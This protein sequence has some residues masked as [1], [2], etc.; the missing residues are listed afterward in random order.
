[1]SR[2]TRPVW[3]FINSVKRTPSPDSL[4]A[5][6]LFSGAGLSDAGYAC[7]GFRFIVH[8]ELEK[9]RAAI[10]ASNFHDSKWIVGDARKVG[11]HVVAEYIKA[12]DRRLDLLVA[13]PP[14]QGMSSSNPSRGKRGTKFAGD[15]EAKN[16]LLL[17]LIPVAKRLRPRVIVAENVRQ[18]LTHTISYRNRKVRIIERLRSALSDYEIFEGVVNVADYGVPQD[19]RRAI[20]VA[21]DKNEPWLQALKKGKVSPWPSHTHGAASAESWI[22]IREWFEAIQYTPLDA[23]SAER[24]SNGHALH[25]V[26][27]YDDHRYLWVSSIP[28]YSGKSAYDNSKCPECGAQDIPRGRIRCPRCNGLL[29]NRPFVPCR[30]GGRLI[31]GFDSSYRRMPANLPARTITTNTSHL[32]SDYKIHPWEHRV[33]S[34]LECA[35]LQTVPRW[36]DWSSA[37]NGG[38]AYLIRKVIGESFPAYFTY[39][40]GQLLFRL[41]TSDSEHI[42]LDE[43]S[44]EQTS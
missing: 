13:T 33:L 8:V 18:V 21:I 36:F 22:T 16:R 11:R 31:K 24:A 39:L 1:M 5:V 34:A 38:H 9:N 14:C 44:M 6:S 43:L 7:A 41:L 15:H 25:N 29:K 4:T 26:P 30:G 12:T 23:G 10:G 19:R 37:I 40:H 27:H 20:I 35:D 32:G 2:R 17:S 3:E 28:P 42:S